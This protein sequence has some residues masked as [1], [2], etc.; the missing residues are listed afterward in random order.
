MATF[1]AVVIFEMGNPEIHGNYMAALVA[2]DPPPSVGALPPAANTGTVPFIF[3]MPNFEA[4]HYLVEWMKARVPG[5][6]AVIIP[7][8]HAPIRNY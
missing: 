3:A 4:A 2:Y 7:S 5:L 6:S 8:V 1:P